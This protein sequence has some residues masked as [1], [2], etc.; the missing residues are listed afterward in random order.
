MGHVT[1]RVG[2][3]QVSYHFAK[4]DDHKNSGSRDIIVFTY[5]E[6]LQDHLIKVL[7]EFLVRSP[8]M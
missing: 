4:S 5:R 7:Y 6:T 2:A 3:R 8:Q 1:L